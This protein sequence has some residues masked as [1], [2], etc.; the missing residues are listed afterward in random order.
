MPLVLIHEIASILFKHVDEDPD[1]SQFIDYP[2]KRVDRDPAILTPAQV[3]FWREEAEERL[4]CRFDDDVVE[5]AC[6]LVEG[7]PLEPELF[8]DEGLLELF[9]DDLEA[10]FPSPPQ[11]I[12]TSDADEDSS[13]ESDES[14]TAVLESEAHSERAASP[15][16]TASSSR[17]V[18]DE[19]QVEEPVRK[20]TKQVLK[21]KR[22]LSDVGDPDSE[23]DG[24]EDAES[25]DD[26][27][28]ASASSSTHAAEA[29][30]SREKRTRTGKGSKKW[31]C[32]CGM[33]FSDKRDMV[34][35]Q[36][37]TKAHRGEASGVYECPACKRTLSRPDAFKRHF[38]VDSAAECLRQLLED[39]DAS[40]LEDVPSRNY[41]KLV[42]L[43]P[44]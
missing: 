21:R 32:H 28:R 38:T 11:R 30:T 4:R 6:R 43:P 24:D 3:L 25:S 37:T 1:L 16:L 13:S 5:A 8:A 7:P 39:A 36:R 29:G 12:P 35:H 20:Q 14:R 31:V 33:T 22:L 9:E 19:P 41:L 17:L 34:R 18:E 26:D 42:P 10:L 40:S 44:T 2:V 27:E 23:V 15:T